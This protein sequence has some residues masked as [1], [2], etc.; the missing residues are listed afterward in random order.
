M[1]FKKYP[2][3]HRLGKSETEGILDGT[4]II[5]EKVDGA[6]VSIWLDK[7]GDI[8]CGSRNKELSEGFNGF[9][10]YVKEHEGI[11]A[12]FE[13]NPTLRLYGEW[14]VRHTIV[15]DETKYKKLYLFDVTEVKDGEE[16]EEYFLQITVEG[17]AKQYG[18][19][20]PQIFAELKNPTEDE[21]KA[22]VGQTNL[23]EKGEGIVI[24]NLDHKDKWGNHC[25]AK[26][27]TKVFKE[28]NGI[29]FGGNNKHSDV[30]REMYIVNKYMTLP[31]IEKIMHKLQPEID[32][33]LDLK[34]I[35][36]I[37]RIAYYDMLTEEIWEI[38]KKVGTVDFR[39]L[40][41]VASKK[42]IQIYKDII[43]N[44]ISVADAVEEKND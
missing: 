21:V 22:F 13:V 34:H 24:K 29:V 20:Y 16:S 33:K 25:Y 15:Y 6:N 27:V 3:I 28:N 42:T 1:T 23:G 17:I 19:D 5:Q 43:N 41:R 36:R 14:L 11:K 8:V 35:P 30:Y 10:E 12:F 31:R 4:C 44:T 39:V 7:R 26:I 18:I 40:K 38:A 37:S 9:V 32:E 2:R